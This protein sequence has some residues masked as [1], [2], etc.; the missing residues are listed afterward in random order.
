MLHT[1]HCYAGLDCNGDSGDGCGSYLE[2]V[3]SQGGGN[4]FD[5]VPVH[6]YGN[7]L[8]WGA[9]SSRFVTNML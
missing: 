7:P 2:A 6:P 8:N 1:I 4:Y 5:A 9:S 3:Y